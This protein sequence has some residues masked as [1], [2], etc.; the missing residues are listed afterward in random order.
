MKTEE[1]SMLKTMAKKCNNQKE[2]MNIDTFLL[3][4]HVNYIFYFMS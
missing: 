2:V 4:S 1:Y 3:Y